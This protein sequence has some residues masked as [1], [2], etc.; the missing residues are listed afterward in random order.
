VPGNVNCPA[1]TR[2]FVLSTVEAQEVP[3]N[4]I[5]DTV[6]CLLKDSGLRLSGA[7]RTSAAAAAAAAAILLSLAL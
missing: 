1:G 6:C 7:A 3:D 5:D 2:K 4:A